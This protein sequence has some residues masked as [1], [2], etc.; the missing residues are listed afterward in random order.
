MGDRYFDLGNLAVNNGFGD[1]DDERA[2]RRLL[3]AAGDAAA[4]RGLRLMRIMSD[5]REG[6]WGVVQSGIS[7]LDFD[8]AGLRG[9]APDARGGRPGRPARPDLAGGRPWRS[10]VTCRR[11][12]AA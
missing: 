3:G 5:F 8:F 4:V 11:A 1:D 12:R 2:A 10:A 7:A 9:R 6:M